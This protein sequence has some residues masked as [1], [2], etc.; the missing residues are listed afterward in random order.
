MILNPLTC[1][2]F[3][4]ISVLVLFDKMPRWAKE[5]E[6]GRINKGNSAWMVYPARLSTCS[7]DISVFYLSDPSEITEAIAS[8]KIPQNSPARC[9]PHEKTREYSGGLGFFLFKSCSQQLTTFSLKYNTELY[10]FEIWWI[11]F[12]PYNTWLLNLKMKCPL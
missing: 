6:T 7:P 4:I 10:Q 1:G 8:H 3:C 2:E 9:S 11:I 12:P 5:H